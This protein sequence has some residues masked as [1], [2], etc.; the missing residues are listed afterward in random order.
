MFLVKQQVTQIIKLKE[1]KI[2]ITQEFKTNQEIDAYVALYRTHINKD[3]DSVLSFCPVTLDKFKG[4]YQTNIG[5]F[6][7]DACVELANPVFIR[8]S[9]KR[10]MGLFLIT[11]NQN[12]YSSRECNK[13]HCI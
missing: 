5:D 10:L 6:I 13:T 2:P 4:E 1:K 9:T 7:A 3:L 12:H 11:G 8:K